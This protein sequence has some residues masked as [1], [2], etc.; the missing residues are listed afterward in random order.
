MNQRHSGTRSVGLLIV[1]AIV[2]LS[3]IGCESAESRAIKKETEVKRSFNYV[4]EK[5]YTKACNKMANDENTYNPSEKIACINYS[6]DIQ[7]TNSLVVPYTATILI[8][9]KEV[10]NFKTENG[11]YYYRRY[12][13]SKACDWKDSIGTWICSEDIVRIGELQ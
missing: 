12:A 2:V 5:E 8:T 7:K 10:A 9:Y 4:A 11:E 13:A 1:I 3:Q 6:Y